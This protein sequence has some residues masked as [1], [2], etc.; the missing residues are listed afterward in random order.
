MQY[1]LLATQRLVRCEYHDEINHTSIAAFNYRILAPD[2]NGSDNNGKGT[3]QD[4]I[5]VAGAE[6]VSMVLRGLRK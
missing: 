3:K 5:R 2:S 4:I 6:G 1:E